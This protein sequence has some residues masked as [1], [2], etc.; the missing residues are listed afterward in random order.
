[1]EG[2]A[3]AAAEGGCAAAACRGRRRR[4]I[5][6]PVSVHPGQLNARAPVPAPPHDR[7][8]GRVPQLGPRRRPSAAVRAL[9]RALVPESSSFPSQA[10]DPVQEFPNFPRRALGPA[11]GPE[12]PTALR[13]G[14][15]SASDPRHGPESAT[16]PRHGPESA[17]DPRHC[18]ARGR[19]P[20]IVPALPVVRDWVS[21]RPRCRD[22]ETAPALAAT[23]P[24]SAT[25][26][27][28]ATDPA[29]ATAAA[30]TTARTG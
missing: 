26:P 16:D 7:A 24:E 28:W 4:S 11:R 19:G 18:R 14:P 29:T 25:D 8:R 2:A 3:C 6:T 20:R 1:M 27:A 12:S 5:A 17:T 23:G 13:H 15:E 21:G 30:S 22:W 10:V 9:R